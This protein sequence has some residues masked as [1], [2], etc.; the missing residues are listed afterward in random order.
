MAN[1]IQV[2]TCDELG[3]T[4]MLKNR[5]RAAVRLSPGKKIAIGVFLLLSVFPGFILRELFSSLH[6]DILF[7]IFSL[8]IPMVGTLV[9][10]R[11][12]VIDVGRYQ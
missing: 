2:E 9:I 1:L 3:K 12:L 6:H 5:M 4:T 7:N 8:A 11:E 10:M